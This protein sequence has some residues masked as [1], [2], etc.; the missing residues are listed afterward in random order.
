MKRLTIIGLALM[1]AFAMSALAAGSASAAPKRLERC[2]RVQPSSEGEGN[3]KRH[4]N[5]KCVEGPV[6]S[7]GNYIIV[8]TNGIQ[9]DPVSECA[10]TVTPGQG[11]Y[12]NATC[13]EKVGE[14]KGNFINVLEQPEYGSCV[15]A[16]PAKSGEFS[17]KNCTKEVK[18]GTGKWVWEPGPEP[19]PGFT[20]TTK[21]ATLET[22]GVGKVVCKKSK[23]VGK[24]TGLESDVDT[25]TFESC[26][27]LGKKCTSA[28]QAAGVIKTFTLKSE[29]GWINQE[30]GEVGTSLTGEGPGGESAEFVCGGE[31]LIKTT[32]SVIGKN[33]GNVN[34]ASAKGTLTFKEEGGKQV[35]EKFEFEPKDTL[36][37]EIVG[38]GAFNSTE[39]TVATQKFEDKS[40]IKATF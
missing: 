3:F 34:L 31:L 17:D 38:I 39:I 12:S 7:S 33:T 9:I 15:V 37:T 27:T 11:N 4:E 32:G 22:P 18:S 13:T 36:S 14:S 1:A 30:K 26:E 5:E 23:D 16:K 40:Q 24:I 35:P 28:G 25:V 6:E 20:S 19:K 2:A 10:E 21:T 29:L 8:W